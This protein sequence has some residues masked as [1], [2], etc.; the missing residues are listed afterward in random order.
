MCG[1]NPRITVP[2][3]YLHSVRRER[4]G[5]EKKRSLK[6]GQINEPSSQGLL[7]STGVLLVEPTL[8]L[9]GN[10]VPPSSLT[11]ETHPTR[12]PFNL[13][14]AF[15]HSKVGRGVPA[16]SPLLSVVEDSY[17]IWIVKYWKGLAYPPSPT[18]GSDGV[19]LIGSSAPPHP[20][21][22]H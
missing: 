15:F 22:T 4:K 8:Y 12:C 17:I 11:N 21:L 18:N 2:A 1:L 6:F 19:P 13:P 9:Q 20:S 16:K 5:E 10:S 7:L 14:T 3:K